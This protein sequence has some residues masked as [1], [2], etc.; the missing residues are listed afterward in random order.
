MRSRRSILGVLAAGLAG[1][2]DHTTST[3]ET[4]IDSP[5]SETPTDSPHG[6]TPTDSP[7]PPSGVSVEAGRLAWERSLGGKIDAGP[8]VFDEQ[9][10]VAAGGRLYWLDR[11]T[12][13]TRQRLI[14]G[15]VPNERQRPDTALQV[16]DG[17][18]YAMLGIS[19]GTGGEDYQLY[20]IDP[21]GDVR[22]KLNTG[23]AGFHSLLGIGDGVVLV[24]TGDDAIS[25]EPQ[26][27]VLAVETETGGRRWEA[28]SGDE[29][30][31][32]VGS[33]R[34][35]VE[36]F[37]AVDG[38]S[39]ADGT[40]QF[41]YTPETAEV[42][43]TAVNELAFVGLE[44]FDGPETSLVAIDRDGQTRWTA[45]G[46]GFVNSLRYENGLFVGGERLTRLDADGGV[47]WQRDASS[48]LTGVPFD[49]RAVY[50]N[51]QSSVVAVRRDDGTQ[52]WASEASD[53][54]IPKAVGGT[55]VVSVDGGE[56]VVFGHDARNGTE[57]W[58]ASLTGDVPAEPAADETGAYLVTSEGGVAKI[59]E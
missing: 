19:I 17:R 45:T 48:I 13:E 52:L 4:P 6:E 41:R 56:R 57:R 2:A 27:T 54:A 59:V 39:L 14:P 42:A 29:L 35:V 53:V 37:G 20:A 21:P 44:R 26:H 34:A 22:W 38:F 12:G 5:D 15:V 40:Q 25:S 1:C 23:V 46:L 33:D 58:R 32:A 7:E 55:T 8:V 43:D 3:G 18:L 28:E 47:R 10:V 24:A 36:T 49:D 51:T 16:H 9:L 30:G 31:G 50:T 11:A